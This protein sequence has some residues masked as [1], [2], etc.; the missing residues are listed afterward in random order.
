MERE[1]SIG[2]ATNSKLPAAMSPARRWT[3]PPLSPNKVALFAN[4]IPITDCNMEHKNTFLQNIEA[5]WY[6]K[7]TEGERKDDGLRSRANL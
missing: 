2:V 3:K 1:E 5:V 4:K 6:K 7:E